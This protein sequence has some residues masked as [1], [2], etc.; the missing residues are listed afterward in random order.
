MSMIPLSEEPEL[1]N[2]RF[3]VVYHISGNEHTAYS[4]AEEITFE[5]TVEFPSDLVPEGVILDRIVGKIELFKQI[6]DEHF[7]ARISYAVE[8]AGDE[9]PQLL[10]VIFGNTSI[11]PG[12][13]VERLL[14]FKRI[15]SLFK[16][17]RFGVNGIRD[18]LHVK[19]RPVICTALKP[20][21]LSPGDLA[22]LAYQ[23]ALGG[24]D[25][26]KDDHGIANQNY[27]YFSD[28]IGIIT[29]AIERANRVTGGNSIYAPN[30]TA[31]FGDIMNRTRLAKEY[32][33][34]ALLV[35]PGLVGFDT[36][37]TIADDENISLPVIAHPAL[38]GSYCIN[39]ESGISHYMLFGQMARLAGADA[40]IFPN[41]G[42]RFS[43]SADECKS[44]AD[45]CR[46]QMGH[47]KS[48][49]P[50]PGGGMRTARAPEMIKTYGNDVIFLIG[51]G[52][53]RDGTDL[54]SN[55]RRFRKLVEDESDRS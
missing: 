28:R 12:I 23:F 24:I 14:P 29:Q 40:S 25:I 15:F 34:G 33:A 19:N 38:L 9:L 48:I 18:I 8:I 36:M 51:G 42:G 54:A 16:G 27:S 37:R 22:E 43:F 55:C 46:D 7:E 11:K 35:A 41:F 6:D 21:G 39:K 49:F 44:I 20:Q 47:Y 50:A 26:I 53:F 1:S 17:P 5:Q 10:N 45:G 4:R 13:R 52:L 30:I 31:S 32:G 2:E 3:S